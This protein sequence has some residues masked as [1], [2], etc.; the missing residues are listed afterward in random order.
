MT[1]IQVAS[2]ATPTVVA[3]ARVRHFVHVQNDSDVD[4]YLQY[5]GSVDVLTV[6][7]GLRLKPGAVIMLEE[8]MADASPRAFNFAVNAVHASTGT[9][10]LRVQES[11]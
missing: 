11:Y 9:K 7:N 8:R 5:D 3:P 4:I 1:A 2:G 6:N 10:L